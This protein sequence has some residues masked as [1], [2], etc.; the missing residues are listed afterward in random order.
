MAWFWAHCN[1]VPNKGLHDPAIQMLHFLH[2]HTDGTPDSKVHGA[3]TGPAWVLSTPDGPHVG[4]MSLAILEP[5]K[6]ISSCAK[7]FLSDHWHIDAFVNIS[8]PRQNGRNLQATF[9]NSFSAMKIIICWL[10]FHRLSTGFNW[11]YASSGSGKDL[12]PSRWQG[13]IWVKDSLVYRQH[14]WHLAS[15]S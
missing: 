3:N 8:R 5:F 12:A 10:K 6:G 4:P 13:F 7:Y 11:H 9:S 14:I 1:F 15:V 2:I